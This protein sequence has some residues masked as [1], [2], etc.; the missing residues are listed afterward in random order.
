M[1]VGSVVALSA[2]SATSPGATG[3]P[4]R[5]SGESPFATCATRPAYVNSEVEPSLAADPG[6]PRRLIAAYQQDRY[7]GGGAR[8]IIV[9][10]SEDGGSTW[11]RA[12]LPVTRCA[13]ASAPFASDPWV[14]AARGGRIYVAT[15]SDVVTVVTSSDWGRTWSQPA[16]LPGA[17]M[18]DKEAVT[19]DPRRPGT[20]Y[21]VWS[22][23]HRTN[24]PGTE[25]DELFSATRDGGR[26]WSTPAVVLRT[27]H[28]AGPEN[29][30]ILIDP[31]NGR[32][33]LLMAWVRDGLAT[34]AK[35]AW[36]LIARS[37]DGG[38]H[39]SKAASFAIGR[40]AAR[41]GGAFIRSSPQVP[42][43]AIDAR[44]AIYGVW[45]DAR[46]GAGD[47]TG[48]LFTRSLDGGFDW[49]RPRRIDRNSTGGAVLPVVAAQRTGTVAVLYLQLD[50]PD[51]TAARYRLATSI[52]GGAHFR[53]QIA[54]PEFSIQNAPL[55][56]PSPLVPGGYFLGDYMGLTPLTAGQFGTA[57][58]TARAA[59]DN[60]T[61]IFYLAA[62]AGESRARRSALDASTDSRVAFAPTPAGLTA[63][64]NA[65]VESI[66]GS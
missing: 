3:E 43:F 56:T 1:V 16:I 40:P 62:T 50:R 54:S 66:T 13:G 60:K 12:A 34:A 31:R 63:G 64:S 52:D 22:D 58:V 38:R 2:A 6:D 57:F 18:P 7:H 47:R 33:Y 19:A 49:S 41:Q 37:A 14:S 39:W 4:V 65:E 8:G 27:G 17:G 30:Q 45:E 61:D 25:S 20:A 9:A 15:L 21:L 11:R 46:F 48:V 59:S 24:P 5:V 35:P 32:L 44:G 51:G 42:S 53:D 55:L 23:Y 10:T 28:R 26:T 29:G 36:M